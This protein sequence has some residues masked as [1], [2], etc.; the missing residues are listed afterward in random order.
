MLTYDAYAIN[1]I[2][3]LEGSK[4]DFENKVWVTELENKADVEKIFSDQMY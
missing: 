3:K 1:K 2:R 4:Y